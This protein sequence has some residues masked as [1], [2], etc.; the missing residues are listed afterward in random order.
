MYPH[1]APPLL[2]RALSVC[3]GEKAKFKPHRTKFNKWITQWHFKAPL[4]IPPTNTH[5]KL[6]RNLADVFDPAPLLNRALPGGFCDTQSTKFRRP[7]FNRGV[8][9]RKFKGPL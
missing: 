9:R 1:A 8:N 4:Q 6:G 3:V 5:F 7:K 2:N